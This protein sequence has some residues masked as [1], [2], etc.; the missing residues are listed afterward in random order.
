MEKVN[1]SDNRKMFLDI[2]NLSL[3]EVQEIQQQIKA[4][5]KKVNFFGSI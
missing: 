2:K 3:K 1:Y 4:D 5:F